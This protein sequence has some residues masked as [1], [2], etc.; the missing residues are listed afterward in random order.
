MK[1]VFL[2]TIIITLF[3][4]HPLSINAQNSNL[5]RGK[6]AFASQKYDQ[7]IEIFSQIIESNSNDTTARYYLGQSYYKS[8]D[9]NK[10]SKQFTLVYQAA[11]NSL[12]GQYSKVA[13]DQIQDLKAPVS[14]KKTLNIQNKN[15][16]S[17]NYLKEISIKGKFIRW[18]LNS[19]P[20]R[21]YIEENPKNVLHFDKKQIDYIKSGID[22]WPKVTNGKILYSYVNNKESAD[23]AILWVNNETDL[24]KLSNK[25][26]FALGV[27]KL[28]ATPQRLYGAI[29]YMAASTPNGIKI[30]PA[31]FK[32]TALHEMGHALGL[33]GHSKNPDDIMYYSESEYNRNNK[34]TQDDI[35]TINLLYS[36][37]ADITNAGSGQF[38]KR[39]PNE[40]K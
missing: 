14:W 33:Q 35:N 28:L 6:K 11:P 22:E 4:M 27:T 40:L 20:L 29:I 13:L 25:K 5:D 2:L 10:A 31:L 21:I 37:K 9:Y 15:A 36:R 7:A 38:A 19:M 24:P 39:Y 12:E 23:I 18:N 34:L 32:G 8:K 17:D 16:E 26:M 30:P 1:K 3:I